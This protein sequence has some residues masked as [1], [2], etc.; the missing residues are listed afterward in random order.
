MNA[1]KNVSS[2]F[3]HRKIHPDDYYQCLAQP[4]K[5]FYEKEIG[6]ESCI[7]YTIQENKIGLSYFDDKR[8]LWDDGI[9]SYAYRHYQIP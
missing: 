8:N 5:K 3:V 4:N 1:A 7:L 6:Q 2:R 9:S